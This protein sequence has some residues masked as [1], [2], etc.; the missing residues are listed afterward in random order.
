MTCLKAIL[1]SVALLAISSPAS[2]QLSQNEV[3][4]IKQLKANPAKLDEARQLLGLQGNRPPARRNVPAPPTAAAEVIVIPRRVSLLNKNTPSVRNA[5]TDAPGL[6]A[7][8]P[9]AVE[10]SKC[11]GWTLLL[12]QDWKDIGLIT[13]PDTTEKAKGA[14]LSFS[15]D[16]VV[17]NQIWNLHGTAGLVYSSL[18]DAPGVFAKSSGVYVTANRVFNSSPA[19]V[20]GDSDKIAFG[21]VGEIGVQTLHAGTHYFRV[22]GGAVEDRLKNT[23]SANVTAEWIPVYSDGVIRIHRPFPVFG[24]IASVR[25]DPTLLVQ[26]NVV[27]GKNQLLDFNGQTQAMR[28]GPQLG[29]HVFPIAEPDSFWSRVSADVT[30]HW[31]YETFSRKGISWLDSSITYN[32]DPDGQFGITASYRKGRDEDTGT[33]TD[34][35]KIAL[36]GKI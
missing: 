29:L 1:G 5:G 28:V 4:F 7:A 2:A 22:R 33:V 35:Y 30:Y 26:Y 8:D 18:L 23:S 17:S 21:G 25:F 3:D 34:I 20:K 12:R 24:G 9:R 32:I 11:A 31:A 36:T 10:L 13:C 16:R 6:A 15:Y 14:E 19:Q 27:T